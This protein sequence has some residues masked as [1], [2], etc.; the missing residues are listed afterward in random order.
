[1]IRTIF[2]DLGNVIIP[3]DSSRLVNALAA[4]APENVDVQ[5]CWQLL[6][7]EH[8]TGRLNEA[9]FHQEYCRLT[10]SSLSS[11]EFRRV[12]TCHFAGECSFDVP[13]LRRLR[14]KYTVFALSNTNEIHM[15]FV[16]DKFAVM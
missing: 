2:F 14:R 11:D 16:L 8:E 5:G 4:A 9:S 10:G 13:F 15:R 1:M 6:L 12:A 7:R 3:L